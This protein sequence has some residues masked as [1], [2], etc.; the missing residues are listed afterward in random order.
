MVN[1]DFIIT[2]FSKCGTNTLRHL[3]SQHPGVYMPQE[4]ESWVLAMPDYERRRP[5]F[6]SQFD[7][8]EPGMIQGTC[9]TL[10]SSYK[11]ENGA[12]RRI[13]NLYPESR[14]L[15]IARNPVK[16]IESSYRE[17]HNGDFGAPFGLGDCMESLPAM[18]HDTCYR[19]RIALYRDVFAEE[20]IH[21]LFLEDLVADTESELA[22]CFRHIG[23]EPLVYP[24]SQ[25]VHLNAGSSKCYDTRLYRWLRKSRVA[26]HWIRQGEPW[27][28]MVAK[29][30]QL[31]RPFR[32]PVVWDDRA[33]S[34]L[35]EQVMPDATGFLEDNGKPPGFW[36]NPYSDFSPG[37]SIIADDPSGS[38]EATIHLEDFVPIPKPNLTVHPTQTGYLLYDDAI[39]QLHQINASAAVVLSLCHDGRDCSD[40]ATA[41]KRQFGLEYIPAG[42]VLEAV[43]SFSDSGILVNDGLKNI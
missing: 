27:S 18:V 15:F 20:Q 19:E 9:G 30:L 43:V 28:D 22:K 33:I 16:R 23:V 34:L 17:M 38:P 11:A 3:V 41:I 29:W 42:E 37:Y 40:I 2:G 39:D 35:N 36:P 24:R 25:E 5:L 13:K 7:A 1:L 21:V 8:A 12:V 10:Y 4:P 26:G 32:H 6:E 31:R 14:F